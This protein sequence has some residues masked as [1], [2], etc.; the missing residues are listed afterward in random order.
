MNGLLLD[1]NVIY[2]YV[3]RDCFVTLGVLGVRIH[4]SDLIEAEFI[5]IRTRKSPNQRAQAHLVLARMRKAIPDYRAIVSKRQI[6]ALTL[7]DL[8]DRHVLAAAISADASI[9][10]TS[11]RRDF[12]KSTLDQFGITAMSPDQALCERFDQDPERMIKAVNN[13]RGRMV[14][15]PLTFAEWLGRLRKAGGENL[16][17]KLEGFSE[18]L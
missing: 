2:S 1:T 9:I 16:A 17:V 12:P 6:E 7:P 10:V 4:W 3:L 11:N 18:Q 15:P 5:A 13:M 8:D 14:N